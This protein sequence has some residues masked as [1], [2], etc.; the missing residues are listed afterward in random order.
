MINLTTTLTTADNE[1]Q[2]HR[3]CLIMCLSRLFSNDEDEVGRGDSL[4]VIINARTI[5]DDDV[6]MLLLLA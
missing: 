3:T 6:M 1:K 4:T 5:D 2:W